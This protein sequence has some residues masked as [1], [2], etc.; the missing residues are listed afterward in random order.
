MAAAREFPVY[1]TAGYTWFIG[2]F[3]STAY[4]HVQEPNG[5]VPDAL[6]PNFSAVVTARSH[7]PSGVN[8]LM[9]DGAVR[10]VPE[11]IARKVWRGLGS[12]N[13]GELVE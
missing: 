1:R 6:I 7:H 8:A 11:S 10:F 9:A 5:R 2:D 12:R 13:G 4:N 3:E